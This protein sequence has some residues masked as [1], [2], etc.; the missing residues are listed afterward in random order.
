[1]IPNDSPISTVLFDIDGVVRHFDPAQV[2]SIE[3]RHTLAPGS[4]MAAAFT[5][6]LLKQVIT[7]VITRREWTEQVGEIISNHSAAFEWEATPGSVDA[8]V[9]ALV[10]E[11]RAAGI[12]VAVLTNGTDAIARELAELGLDSHFDAIFNS[13][14][15][16]YAKPD[17][18]AFGH[19]CDALSVDPAHVF[20]T[21]DSQSKLAGA[22]ELG[23]A[24]R[25]FTSVAALRQQLSELWGASG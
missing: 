4:I 8:E 5:P 10:E 7:G 2:A 14:D 22:I 1:M 3:E 24:A 20:F 16:G 13:A 18:R 11:L 6:A 19:V 9:V 12:T 17:V 25:V 23:M 21:D 15:I